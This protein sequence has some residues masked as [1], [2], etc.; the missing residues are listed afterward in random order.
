M[1]RIKSLGKKRKIIFYCF[2]QRTYETIRQN[3]VVSDAVDE[4]GELRLMGRALSGTETARGF[5]RL[6]KSINTAWELFYLIICAL[7]TKT[8][9]IHFKALNSG[10]LRILYLL[11]RKRTI[12]WE[13]S[14]GGY[15]VLEEK[16]DNVSRLR[17]WYFGPRAAGSLIHYSDNWSLLKNPNFSIIPRYKLPLC[18]VSKEWVEFIEKRQTQYF[19]GAFREF[20]HEPTQTILTVMGGAGLLG[21]LDSIEGSTKSLLIDIFDTLLEY[22]RGV[23]VF[24]KPPPVA[25]PNS[26]H[27]FDEILSRYEG[28]PLYRTNLHPA[29]LATRSLLFAATNY[30]T[31]FSVASKLGVPTIE[32]TNCTQKVLEIT[33]GGSTRP[34]FVSDFIQNDKEA[35]KKTVLRI[36]NNPNKSTGCLSYDPPGTTDDFLASL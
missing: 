36:I 28:R 15:G 20:G 35:L 19:E 12:Y 9:F 7:F 5:D 33:N 16:I 21:E 4:I 18:Y 11:N 23:P 14:A 6:L 24:F 3:I 34:E 31:T 32:Y 26:A 13:G 8:T 22:G 27:I 10:P 2:D 17:G 25:D 1:M 30:S 29:I